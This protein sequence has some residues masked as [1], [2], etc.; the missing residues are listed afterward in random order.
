MVA[1]L[2]G[3]EPQGSRTAGTETLTL[4]TPGNVLLET[5]WDE[6]STLSCTSL[7]DVSTQPLTLLEMRH[8]SHCQSPCK[9]QTVVFIAVSRALLWSKYL[10]LY[11]ILS[12][13]AACLWISSGPYQRQSLL[14]L[15]LWGHGF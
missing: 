7:P 11:H 3:L 6:P 14:H 10:L 13:L 5:A 15:E 2:Y 12:P 8:V 4:L 1:N 9:I